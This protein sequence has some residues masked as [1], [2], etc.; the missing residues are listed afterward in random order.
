[1]NSRK[2]EK[3][4]AV[5]FMCHQRPERSFFFKGKQFPLCARCTGILIGYLLGIALS[6]VTG[7]SHYLWFLTL[8]LPMIIDGGIQ[9]IKG[10]ESNNLRR[11]CTG[12]MGGIGIIYIFISIHKF[13]VWWLTQL[14]LY[15]GW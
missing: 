1:M 14:F 15:M 3:F 13:T 9:Q 8:L 7:C 5:A 4:L 2:F 11:F 12:V 10:I 6:I